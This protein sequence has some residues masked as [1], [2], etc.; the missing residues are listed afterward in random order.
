V[1]T[2]PDVEV[3]VNDEDKRWVKSLPLLLTAAVL[4]MFAGFSFFKNGDSTASIASF[5]AGLVLLGSWATT[6]IVDW[7][8]NRGGPR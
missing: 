6:A 3:V 8:T 2:V 5:T 1:Y 4:L 7:F